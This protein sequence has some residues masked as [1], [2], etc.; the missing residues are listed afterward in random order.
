M[1]SSTSL[2]RREFLAT[3]S[4]TVA[5][6]GAWSAVAPGVRAARSP[7][8]LIGIGQIGLGTR[9]GDLINSVAPVPGVKVVAVCDVYQPHLQKGVERSRNP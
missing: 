7:N 9:G 2:T 1:K 8:D 6:A 4:K 5:A 3:T